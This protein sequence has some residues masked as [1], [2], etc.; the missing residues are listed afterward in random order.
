MGCKRIESILP[1]INDSLSA[2]ILKD[3]EIEIVL[4][5][6]TELISRVKNLKQL[7]INNNGIISYGFD[8]FYDFVYNTLELVNLSLINDG[9][10]ITFIKKLS[11]SKSNNSVKTLTLSYASDNS[12]LETLKNL[13]KYM[14]L[15]KIILLHE[16]FNKDDFPSFAHNFKNHRQLKC[17]SVLKKFFQRKYSI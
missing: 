12:D 4:V 16:M 2:L 14:S 1:R 9:I 3:N 11:A 13:G 7:S 5:Q 17:V 10:F 6:L 15:E 8:D